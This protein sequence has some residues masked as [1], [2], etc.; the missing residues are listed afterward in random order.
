MTEQQYANAKDELIGRMQLMRERECGRVEPIVLSGGSEDE[1]SLDDPIVPMLSSEREKARSEYSDYCNIVKPRKHVPRSYTGST[2]QLGSI[3]MGKVATR[4]DSIK[5]SSPFITCNL[6]DYIDDLGHFDL[7]AFLDLQ[8]Q[9]FPILYKLAVCL[10]S[11]RTNEVGCERFFSTAGYVSCPRRTSL[12]V[13]NYECL[14]TLK[15]NMQHVFIDERWVVD[16]YMAMER[17]R[18]WDN[19]D[20]VDDMNVLTLEREIFAES[21]GVNPE[22]L[23]SV[24][25]IESFESVEVIEIDG[26]LAT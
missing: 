24:N 5:A 16:K 22:T 6:A 19:L 21:L 7:V 17:N 18:S 20:T 11:V 12:K 2:L 9:C 26:V 14:A 4:G 1:D 3:Q 23:P 15:A 10:A 25:D 13:R 8:N